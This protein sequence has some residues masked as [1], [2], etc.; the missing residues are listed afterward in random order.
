MFQENCIMDNDVPDRI[1]KK[2]KRGWKKKSARGVLFDRKIPIEVKGKSYD[3][4]MKPAILHG[5]EPL[6]SNISIR[7]VL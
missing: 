1:K 5:N 4:A 2:K 7:W 3:R 6:R